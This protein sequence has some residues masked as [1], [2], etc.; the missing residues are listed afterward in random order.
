MQE[1]HSTVI[2]RRHTAVQRH[3]PVVDDLAM[4]LGGGEPSKWNG[5]FA[6]PPH[7]RHSDD[8]FHTLVAHDIDAATGR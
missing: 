3:N 7:W 2:R 5:L 1:P 4:L 8:S 6:R